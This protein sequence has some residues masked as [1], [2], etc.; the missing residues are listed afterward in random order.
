MMQFM[1]ASSTK[2]VRKTKAIDRPF[3][4]SILNRARAIASQY[5]IVLE[6][7]R[8]GGFVSRALEMPECIGIGKTAGQCVTAT[9][10]LLISA[11]ATMLEMNDVPPSPTTGQVRDEHIDVQVSSEEKLLFEDAARSRGFRAV[12]DFVRSTTLSTLRR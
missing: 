7:E 4:E 8:D 6:S 2:S 3:D 12:A 1:R 5:K 11:I 9:R 10:E